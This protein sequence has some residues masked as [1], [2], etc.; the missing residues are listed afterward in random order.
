MRSFL[1]LTLVILTGCGTRVFFYQDGQEQDVLASDLASC[2]AK[3]LKEAP[4]YLIE[5]DFEVGAISLK[6]GKRIFVPSTHITRDVNLGRRARL[7]RQCMADNGYIRLELKRCEAPDAINIEEQDVLPP[8]ERVLCY[9]TD[10]T[11]RP[12]FVTN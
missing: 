10:T 2:E 1:F 7:E 11:R 12:F 8:A 5:D 6:P 3:A 4:V 9:V